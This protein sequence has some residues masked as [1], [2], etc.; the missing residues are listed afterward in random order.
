[1][2]ADQIGFLVIGPQKIK[3]SEGRK[4][5]ILSLLE[6]RIRTL[7]ELTEIADTPDAEVPDELEKKLG[8]IPDDGRDVFDL[9]NLF[10]NVRGAN[11]KVMARK[12]LQ[13]IVTEYNRGLDY[14]DVAERRYKNKLIIFAGGMSWGEEPEGYGYQFFK[15]VNNWGLLELLGIV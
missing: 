3:L 5:K 8:W 12:E 9:P 14:R 11:P 6:S 4:K 7:Q 10:P 1:M 13:E 15:R 2:G